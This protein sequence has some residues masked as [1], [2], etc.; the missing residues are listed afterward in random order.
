MGNNNNKSLFPDYEQ[1]ASSLNR[2][3]FQTIN[4]QKSYDLLAHLTRIFLEFQI[5]LI[6]SNN[7]LRYILL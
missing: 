2:L 4:Y 3:A 1:A 5:F 7:F 6:D